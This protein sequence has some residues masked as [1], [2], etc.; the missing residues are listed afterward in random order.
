MEN[1]LYS[2]NVNFVV[3]FLNGSAGE[4]RIFVMNAIKNNVQDN[5]SVNYQRINYQNAKDK[6]NVQ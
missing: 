6:E 1:S 2:L 5:I 4:I 3:Q